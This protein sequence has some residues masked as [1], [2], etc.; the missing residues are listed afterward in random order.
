MMNHIIHYYKP[1]EA[2]LCYVLYYSDVIHRVC[3]IINMKSS[4]H[5]FT[6]IGFCLTLNHGLKMYIQ[7]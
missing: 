7:K 5:N 4:G 1:T 2:L 3:D 6:S